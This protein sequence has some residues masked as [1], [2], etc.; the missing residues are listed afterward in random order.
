MKK[1]TLS[2]ICIFSIVAFNSCRK[3]PLACFNADSYDVNI[4]QT[5]TFTSC[6]VDADKLKWDFSDGTT[7]EGTT[8]TH[9]YATYG[10]YSV[11]HTA[12]TKNGKHSNV[13][14]QTVTV[15]AIYVWVGTWDVASAC[16][17]GQASYTS[18]ITRWNTDSIT[19][20]NFL[21]LGWDL[22]ALVMFTNTDL[23]FSQDAFADVNNKHYDIYGQATRSGNVV[24]MTYAISNTAY[25]AA[26]GVPWF[27][28][29]CTAVLTKQ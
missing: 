14:Y 21:G 28:D 7:A 13:M 25:Y 16:G 6:S 3:D 15:N 24:S 29:N 19:I 10:D 2:A 26:E 20:S 9:S 27:A 18:Q 12:E 8:V 17:I 1:I 11:K 5:V 4:G 22:H 23:M